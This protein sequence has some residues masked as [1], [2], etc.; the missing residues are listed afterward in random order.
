MAKVADFTHLYQGLLATPATCRIRVYRLASGMTVVIASE[1]PGNAVRAS[2]TNVAEALATEIR[3]LYVV[4]GGAMV[5]I[6]HYPGAGETFDRVLFQWDG[7][8]YSDPAWHPSSRRQV[9][10]MIGEALE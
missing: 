6:E 3:G 1:Q 2:I 8:A 10:A 4:P 9:E 7:L 5:W